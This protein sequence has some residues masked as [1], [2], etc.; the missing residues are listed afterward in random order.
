MQYRVIYPIKH[1]GNVYQPDEIVDF[2]GD[3]EEKL[4]RAGAIRPVDMPFS[5]QAQ[6]PNG[7][8]PEPMRVKDGGGA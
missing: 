6:A 4:L 7:Q 3:Q 8:A 2:F 5:S 1:D